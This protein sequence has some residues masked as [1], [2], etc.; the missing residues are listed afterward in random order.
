ML[1]IGI[2]ALATPVLSAAIGVLGLVVNGMIP[3]AAMLPVF[4]SW[5]VGDAVGAAVLAGPAGGGQVGRSVRPARNFARTVESAVEAKCF[6]WQRLIS[7]Q[8]RC[9]TTISL[10]ASYAYRTWA[11]SP[12]DI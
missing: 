5:Y 10:I 6:A 2:G 9:L 11:R 1:L 7:A 4:T 12:F 8:V 3:T